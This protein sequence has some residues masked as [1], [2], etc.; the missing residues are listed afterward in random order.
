MGEKDKEFSEKFGKIVSHYVRGM[1]SHAEFVDE[2]LLLGEEFLGKTSEYSRD[3][4][5]KIIKAIYLQEE[6]QS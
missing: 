5:W 3:R 4:A 1:I 2:S 6:A